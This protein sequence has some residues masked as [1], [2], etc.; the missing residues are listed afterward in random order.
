MLNICQSKILIIEF[1]ALPS[2]T[3]TKIPA[4]RIATLDDLTDS[5]Q[6]QAIVA[7]PFIPDNLGANAKMS[8]ALGV[9]LLGAFNSRERSMVSP[10]S[11]PQTILNMC[12]PL[13][14]EWD[15]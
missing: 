15:K 8:L 10:L 13:Q 1:I 2:T 11:S 12:L 9:H 3:S 5:P 14:L 7:P 4:S 6:Y